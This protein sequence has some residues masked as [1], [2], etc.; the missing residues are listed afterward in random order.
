MATQS[1]YP[2]DDAPMGP[3][4]GNADDA[5][6]AVPKKKRYGWRYSEGKGAR[7]SG[8]GGGGGGAR[9]TVCY[10]CSYVAL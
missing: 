1:A 4:D 10:Q 5:P 8:G 9:P 2:M 3:V 7:Q 6:I